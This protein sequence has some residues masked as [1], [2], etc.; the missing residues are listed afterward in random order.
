V[1]KKV[2]KIIPY[3]RTYHKEAYELLQSYMRAY[4]CAKCGHPVLHI[5]CCTFCGTGTPD[6]KEDEE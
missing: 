4:P 2:K 3:G 5:Y 6:E 1:E